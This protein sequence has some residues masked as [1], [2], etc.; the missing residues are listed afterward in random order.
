[1]YLYTKTHTP[2]LD[3]LEMDIK[4]SSLAGYYLYLRWDDS[5]INELRV[6][7]TTELNEEEKY[8]LDNLVA[9]I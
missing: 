3:H 2:D 9:Q 4:S 8:L 7:L 1:M 5:D 6:F